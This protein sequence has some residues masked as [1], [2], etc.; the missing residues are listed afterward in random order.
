MSVVPVKVKV[1]LILSQSERGDREA[2]QVL[3][4]PET[5]LVESSGQKMNSYAKKI[6]GSFIKSQL[7]LPRCISARNTQ[8]QSSR[9]CDVCHR[10]W[11]K[12]DGAEKNTSDFGSIFEWIQ[13]LRRRVR[14]ISSDWLLPGSMQLGLMGTVVFRAVCHVTLI[15]RIWFLKLLDFTIKFCRWQYRRLERWFWDNVL[16]FHSW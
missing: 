5:L 7:P 8:S 3:D 1:P 6:S 15:E 9:F 12:C 2:L 11:A 13:Q 4:G 10:R 16:L 14:S